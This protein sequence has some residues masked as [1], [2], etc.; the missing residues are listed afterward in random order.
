MAKVNYLIHVIL[1]VLLF[2]HTGELSARTEYTINGQ[3]LDEKERPV[4]F[5]NVALLNYADSSIIAGTASGQTGKFELK[6]NQPGSYLISVSFVGFRPLQKRIELSRD[7]FVDLGKIIMAERRTELNEVVINQERLKAKQQIDK[8]TY[9]VNSALKKSS[10]T[11]TD[12]MRHIP[13]V[14]VDLMQNISLNGSRNIVFLVNGIERDGAFLAQVEPDKIDKI[15]IQNAPGVEYDG[16]VSGVINVIMKKSENAGICGRVHANIP[17]AMDEVFSFP[18]ANLNYTFDKLTL[19]TSYNGGFSYFD[20]ETEDKRVFS[21]SG[22]ALEINKNESLFQENWSHKL[23]FGADYFINENNQFNVYG[24]ISRFS[25]EQSGNFSIN[26]NSNRSLNNL[27]QYQK[28]EH[29]LNHSA[30]ASI[31][32]KGI[33]AENTELSL[34]A[35]YYSL[36]SENRLRL[37]EP[38]SGTEQMS[39]ARPRNNSLKTRLDFRFDINEFVGVKVGL[40]QNLNHSSDD[41]MPEFDYTESTSAAYISTNYSRNKVQANAGIRAEYLQYGKQ[42][43]FKDQVIALP[44]LNLGYRFSGGKSMRISYNQSIVR[45]R[46]FQLNPNLRTIDFYTTQ[47]GNPCLELELHHDFNLDYSLTFGNNFL[48]TGVFYTFKQN[49]VETLTTVKDELF[50]EKEIQNPG[51]IHQL[52]IDAS[53]SFKLHKNISLNPHVRL[54][55]VQTRPNE[56]AQSFQVGSKQT[57][58][59]ESALSAVFM[60]KNDLAFS[61]SAHC[62]SAVTGIQSNYREDALYF[63]S[64]EKTFFKQLKLGITSAVPLKKS[65]KYQGYNISAQN[66]SQ[67]TRDN[68]QMSLFPVWFKLSYSF[69]SGLKAR[70]IER[71]NSFEEQRPKKGF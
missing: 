2:M 58:N 4:M 52:G 60:M 62:N 3:L 13:G 23:H 16:E 19:Y 30:F 17:T 47:K 59:F 9:Y 18:T 38:D 6:Y 50:L 27:L 51:A 33:F 36:E 65:F 39:H 55:Y 20:I 37:S 26:E 11:G 71:D 14:Q 53:G 40:E 44:S 29:D 1:S 7:Q 32:Y 10:D 34:D 12:V 5:A 8:T 63:I 41:L 21:S 54:F 48:N 35:N 56:L 49:V 69:A 22:P 42:Y 28:D 66:F 70:R 57:F 43:S 61:L 24:F 64:L 68:I 45:P 31:F 25:N 46:I 15:E 67:T